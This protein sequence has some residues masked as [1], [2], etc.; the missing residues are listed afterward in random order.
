[1]SVPGGLARLAP[2][3]RGLETS[4]GTPTFSSPRRLPAA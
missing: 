3:E 4:Y 1:M 2:P